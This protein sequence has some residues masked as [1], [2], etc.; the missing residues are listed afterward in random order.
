MRSWI[1][2]A[3]AVV[4][5]SL[6]ISGTYGYLSNYRP[7]RPVDAAAYERNRQIILQYERVSLVRLLAAPER[8]EGRKVE[9]A[10]FVTLQSEGNGLH[11]D[12]DA[13]EAG[14]RKNAIW[15]DTRGLPASQINRNHLRYGEVAGT[16]TASSL[17]QY[18]SYSGTLTQVRRIRPTYTLSDYARYRFELKADWLVS[19]V[20]SAP[21]LILAGWT[22]LILLW[23]FR[24][25]KSPR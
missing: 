1:L 14:L 12:K 4:V 18:S 7:S 5:L 23:L 24:R 6:V 16:F 17:G 13:Y 9:V 11:L 20:L 15:I 2:A 3:I 8:Y 19:R 21:F 22:G 25:R 10:G